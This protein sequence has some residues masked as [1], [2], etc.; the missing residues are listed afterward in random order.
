MSYYYEVE[1]LQSDGRAAVLVVEAESHPDAKKTA[2]SDG[3]VLSTRRLE[4]EP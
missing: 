3:T 1:V 2:E 4:G